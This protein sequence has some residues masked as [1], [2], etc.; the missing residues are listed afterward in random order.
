MLQV[1]TRFSRGVKVTTKLVLTRKWDP[2]EAAMLI[3]SEHISTFIV[4]ATMT[5]AL[6]YHATISGNKPSSL[7][8]VGMGGAA[9]A[10]DQVKILILILQ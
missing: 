4:P 7:L 2:S 1:A 9:R 3:K 10:P 8:S 6:I 5:G